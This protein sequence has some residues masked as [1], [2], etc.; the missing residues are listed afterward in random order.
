MET[1]V[2]KLATRVRGEK[3]PWSNI[4]REE[5]RDWSRSEQK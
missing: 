5:R 2:A 1:S 4:S 3:L